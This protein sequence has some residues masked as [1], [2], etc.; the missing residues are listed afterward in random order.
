MKM[1]MK[2][3]EESQWGGT[4]MVRI[5]ILFVGYRFVL[6]HFMASGWTSNTVS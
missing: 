1:K 2:V 4:K 3:S 5:Y 6:A